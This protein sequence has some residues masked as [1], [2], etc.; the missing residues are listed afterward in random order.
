MLPTPFRDTECPFQYRS[1]KH[2][3]VNG[4]QIDLTEAAKSNRARAALLGK[5]AEYV[6][7]RPGSLAGVARFNF[8]EIAQRSHA[9]NPHAPACRSSILPISDDRSIDECWC[10]VAQT[11]SK[12]AGLLAKR[13][14]EKFAESGKHPVA[15]QAVMRELSQRGN[16]RI[17]QHL[18]QRAAFEFQ[19]VQFCSEGAI[20]I[21]SEDAEA[22][23]AYALIQERGQTAQEIEQLNA[24]LF[25]RPEV[26][27]AVLHLQAVLC[28]R[29]KEFMTLDPSYPEGGMAFSEI[30]LPDDSWSNPIPSSRFLK[31][32]IHNVGPWMLEFRNAPPKELL[33]CAIR[34]TKISRA[35]SQIIPVFR[36]ENGA[37][38]LMGFEKKT[39]PAVHA[40]IRTA[41]H[42]LEKD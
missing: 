42:V 31:V 34:A 24:L 38:S 19:D 26:I 9:I 36:T 29:L 41:A 20:P 39:C 3:A 8:D 35:F 10:D 2:L 1:T 7:S 15:A 30:A 33:A 21:G 5:F 25:N 13:H 16:T 23:R 22:L 40:L 14:A 27:A 11:G 17:T 12:L 6:V 32:M 4:L 37:V 28:E 18:K